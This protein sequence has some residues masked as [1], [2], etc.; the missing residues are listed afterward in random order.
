MIQ[1]PAGHAAQAR[2]R[3]GAGHLDRFLAQVAAGHHQGVVGSGFEQQVVQ[4]GIRQH[5]AQGSIARRDRPGRSPLTQSQNHDRAPWTAQRSGFRIVHLA[6][7]ARRFQVAHHYR[8]GLVTAPLARAQGLYCARVARV[9]CQME[10]A[11]ALNGEDLAGREALP[12]FLHRAGERGAA[13]RARNR[14]GVES[15]VRRTLELGAAGRTHRESG[16]G[17]ARAI[18]GDVA[19][20]RVARPAVGAIEEGV[21]VAAGGRVAQFAF[22]LGASCDV[23]RYQRE[24]AIP[25]HALADREPPARA[26]AG[27][28]SHRHCLYPC[29]GRWLGAERG[30]ECLYRRAL[31]LDLG[32]HT[33]GVV[34]DPA[35][36]VPLDR[37]TMHEGAESH[38]LHNAA[39]PHL[40]SHIP[41]LSIGAK[42]G[43]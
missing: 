36:Q 3:T 17:G 39:H 42:V 34:T 28:G 30:H 29:Q 19:H 2:T 7:G 43:P 38:A 5:H 41:G 10:A 18:V 16:H 33:G 8:E 1:E 26:R 35:C 37:R 22:A 20:N 21:P 31:A 9:A 12:R 27:Q 11:Q 15:P 32:E 25:R 13:A 40:N 4:R 6:P 14:L 24:A 23:G